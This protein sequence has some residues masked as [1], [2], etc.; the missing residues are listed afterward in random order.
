MKKELIKVNNAILLTLIMTA[1]SF[2]TDKKR[3]KYR[4]TEF[5][6]RKLVMRVIKQKGS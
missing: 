3:Y 1:C 5:Q 4:K 2:N 6:E